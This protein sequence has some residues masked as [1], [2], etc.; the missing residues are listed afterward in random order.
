MIMPE[1]PVR[2]NALR[3]CARAGH[4]RQNLL[5]FRPL[6]TAGTR[7]M[8]SV[9]ESLE[10]IRRGAEEILVEEELVRKLKRGRNPAFMMGKRLKR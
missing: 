2:R 10:I 1:K 5:N 9:E 6:L 7:V 8:A 4:V 3:D